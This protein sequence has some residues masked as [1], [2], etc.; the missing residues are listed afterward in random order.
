MS[1]FH[2]PYIPKAG[3]LTEAAIMVSVA[4]LPL[5]FQPLRYEA[6]ETPRAV[7]LLLLVLLALPG[8]RAGFSLNGKQRWLVLAIGLWSLAL[9]ASAV[10]SLSPARSLVGDVGRGM[11][12]ITQLTLVAAVSLGCC[13]EPQKLW[14]WL[15]L[16]A[17]VTAVY[18]ILQTLGLL[19]H[20]FAERAS[21]TFG[22]PTHAGSWYALAALWL[23]LGRIGYETELRRWR[24]V[25]FDGGI[26]LVLVALLLTGARGA[27]IGFAGGGIT[28]LA[29]WAAIQRSRRLALL[30]L[31][32]GLFMAGGLVALNHID[33]NNTILTRLPLISRLNPNQPDTPRFTREL[34]WSNAVDIARDFPVMTDIE[35]QPDRWS[36][37]RPL[38]GYGQE[39]LELVHRPYV[40]AELRLFESNRPVDRAH[41]DT[42]DQLVTT[43]WLG[44]LTRWLVWG[45][46]WG[47]GLSRMGLWSWWA[48]IFALIGAG[49]A[50]ASF[51]GQPIAPLMPV[52][53]TWLGVILWLLW[54][55][56]RQ[57][58]NERYRPV[59]PRTWIALTLLAASM[60]D[61]QFSF[62]TVSA[63]WLVWLSVG[64]L[65][66]RP[67]EDVP[68]VESK[69][70]PWIALAGALLIRVLVLSDQGLVPLVMLLA[71]CLMVGWVWT[72]LTWR[73]IVVI[74]G[75]WL[76]GWASAAVRDSMWTAVVD[77]AL[78]LIAVGWVWVRLSFEKQDTAC[79]VPTHARTGFARRTL[80]AAVILIAAVLAIRN[81]AAMISIRRA[82]T[83]GLA[84]PLVAELDTATRL[85]PWDDRVAYMTASAK[86]QA[87]FNQL[88]GVDLGLL[89][90][91]WADARRA[92]D[93]DLYDGN[94]AFMLALI[95][96]QLPQP[97]I[98][99]IDGYYRAAVRLN[100]TESVIW[101]NWSG[102]ALDQRGDAL[103]AY[104]YAGEALRLTPDDPYASLIRQQAQQRMVAP[105]R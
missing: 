95:E 57:D 83:S 29:L 7:I 60:L 46:A 40:T 19:T 104:R 66:I 72:A 3:Q 26:L 30:L 63:G 44:L 70:F 102:F 14:R 28:A 54:L 81:D 61:G 17:V 37:L 10:F 105:Y 38:V 79:H 20:P 25:A 74:A 5:L 103:A 101:S 45:A 85:R 59:H 62:V 1:L 93:L 51:R 32:G 67:Q 99:R 42:L 12:V 89:D 21:G 11:G 33:W 39:M 78:V 35:N 34:I 77:M 84:L 68:A 52:I 18:G 73:Q 76:V 90:E 43:G 41:N 88:D 27:V 53:G 56:F 87:A 75:W 64:G 9:I 47:L 23:I 36:G 50:L 94:Y 82:Y 92:A 65:L 91:A 100:P 8:V 97:Q 48:G 80:W 69:F 58:K 2:N 22:S 55:P 31:T 6:Y 15:W 24:Q 4:L 49:V 16:V 71:T 96:M 13:V 98:S 86:Y